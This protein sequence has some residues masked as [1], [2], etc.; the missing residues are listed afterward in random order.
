MTVQNMTTTEITS[1]L[2]TLKKMI[3]LGAGFVVVGYLLTAVAGLQDPFESS[4]PISA[5]STLTS[6]RSGASST[7]S[8][9]SVS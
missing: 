8:S 2:G 5:D 9:R 3:V 4:S 6:R 7:S 1:T